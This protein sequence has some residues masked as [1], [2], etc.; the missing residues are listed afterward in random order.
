[1]ED[2]KAGKY[3]TS[4]DFRDWPS[5]KLKKTIDLGE[6]GLMPLEVRFLHNPEASEGYVGCAIGSTVWRFY[7]D[8]VGFID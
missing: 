6:E 2:V 4:I 7:K 5:L 1:M 8:L 3:G